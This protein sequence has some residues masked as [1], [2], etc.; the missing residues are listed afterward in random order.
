MTTCGGGEGWEGGVVFFD[1]TGA[2]DES[3]LDREEIKAPLFQ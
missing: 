2:T 3:A 1:S